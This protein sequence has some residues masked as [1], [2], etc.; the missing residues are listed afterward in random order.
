MN[1][2]KRILALALALMLALPA[3]ALATLVDDGTECPNPASPA[4]GL[5]V[6]RLVESQSANCQRPWTEV[7]RCEGCGKTYTQTYPDYGTHEFEYVGYTE[8]TCTEWG[9]YREECRVCG[10]VQEVLEGEPLGHLPY[11]DEVLYP[12]C[13]NDGYER[14]SCER[15][16]QVLDREILPARGHQWGN[17][18]ATS[19]TCTT[20]GGAVRVCSVCG[21]QEWDRPTDPLGH[22]WDGGR[23]TV[24]PTCTKNGERTFTCNR[25]GVTRTESIPA[26]GHK[27][28]RV[29]GWPPTCTENG[30]G[31]GEKCTVC[32]AVITA[33]NVIPATGHDWG[34]WNVTKAPTATEQGME[35]RICRN[36]SSHREYRYIPARG[37][38]TGEPTGQPT[39]D[40]AQVNP[41]LFLSAAWAEDAGVGKLYEGAVVEYTLT[42]TNT[43]DC[44]LRMIFS[45]PIFVSI[46]G[47]FGT[48]GLGETVELQ[49]G[50]TVTIAVH[51]SVEAV[52]VENRAYFTGWTFAGYYDDAPGEV[53]QVNSNAVYVN[54]PLTDPNGP[55]PAL[56]LTAAWAE[57]AGEGKCYEG[58]VVEFTLTCTNTG[59][60]P[61]EV[62]LE[63]PNFVSATGPS[64]A[65]S[66]SVTLQPGE[67]VTVVVHQPIGSLDVERQTYQ[68]LWMFMGFYI[69]AEG[70]EWSVDSNNADINIPLTYPQD[71]ETEEPKPA[72]TLIKLYDDPA[73]DVYE[74][75]D[76]GVGIF[77]DMVNTGNVP[78]RIVLFAYSGIGFSAEFE[79][80]ILYPGEEDFDKVYFTPPLSECLT[81]GT[82]T[83]DL[84]G[85][86]DLYLYCV[87]YDPETGEELC[88]TGEISGH[89]K[90]RK[91]GP[92]EWEI[93]DESQLQVTQDYGYIGGKV[94]G[95]L[96]L[97]AT[98]FA[99]ATVKNV[100][101]VDVDG[102]VIYIPAD[103]Y[104]HPN[105][106]VF[107]VDQTF[108]YLGYPNGKVTQEDVDRGYIYWPPVRVT[109]TDP[110]SGKVKTAYSESVTIPVTGD[111][112]LVVKKGIAHGPAN[113]EYF[114]AGEQID[115]VLT[116][117]NT[118]TA[119]IRNVTVTDK[120]V[121]VGSFAEIAPG[122]TKPC[123]VPPHIVSIYDEI[124]GQVI[125]MATAKG[126]TAWGAEVTRNSNVVVVPAGSLSTVPLIPPVLKEDGEIETPGTPGGPG[127]PG[128]GTPETPG[129]PG[130]PGGGEDPTG[131]IHGLKVGATIYKTDAHGPANGE[132]YV[133]GE[134][135]EFT[136]TVKNVGDVALENVVIYDSLAGIKPIDG[137]ASIA[138]GAE[139]TFTFIYFITQEDVNAVWVVNTAGLEYT[140][141]GGIKGTPMMSNQV[142]I[143]AG[144][145]TGTITPGGGTPG[146]WFKPL[147]PGGYTPVPGPG[148][149]PVITPGGSPIYTSGDGH[150]IIGPD[151]KLIKTDEHG[152]PIL[153]ENGNYIYLLGD[154]PVS[155]E[156][157]LTVMG[158]NEMRYTLHACANHVAAAQAAEAACAAGTAQGYKQAADIWR[159]EIDKMYQTLFEAA[160]DAAKATVMN[161]RLNLYAYVGTY[162]AMGTDPIRA[163]RTVAE[164]LRMHCAELCCMTHTVP[165]PLPNSLLG[166]YAMTQGSSE[167]AASSRTIAPLLG[168]DSEVV[169]RFDA[170]FARTLNEV[171][172]T[173]R[174]A[175]S[176]GRQEAFTQA[177]GQ[178]QMALDSVVNETYKA[179]DR[180]ARKQIAACRLMLDQY[181]A[182]RKAMLG[183][184]YQAAP[185][186]AEEA[187]MNLY[188]NAALEAAGGR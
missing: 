41:A 96:P 89:Y 178:W 153:D 187:L 1:K 174:G 172:D 116:V 31:Y 22:D 155:C 152:N 34:P 51:D 114:E 65:V 26:N 93:P 20:G 141:N 40:P 182:A 24:N 113:G 99:V 55:N 169:E 5:H 9:V 129:K 107:A 44:P 60:C 54:I 142:Y 39:G 176:A 71:G 90:V 161:D 76:T 75:D 168:S 145:I 80:G 50:E 72:L 48:V 73:K 33:Q 83:E 144:E 154:G 132:Y 121:T 74:P 179:A 123:S 36:D 147:P 177:Q 57:N 109:W 11:V 53:Q 105:S 52:D 82:E 15:C 19:A 188:K 137:A 163:Q 61:V 100:G 130:T 58:A 135:A 127:G 101:P 158:S 143:R 131:P 79:E 98:Y 27:P 8:P 118:S 115:W 126:T 134:Q 136:I 92:K 4:A 66:G 185:W 64:G 25:C 140:Y 157:R 104:T 170:S 42:L 119:P 84:M 18:E 49:P 6:W 125:N 37:G 7:F 133:L 23:V 122:E 59:D 35:E 78:L 184:L 43:G 91:P 38:A 45:N 162:E 175:G 21:A 120:G 102:Y 160:D 148:G 81:P 12:T 29:W 28:E 171:M 47:P 186:V 68:S 3:G 85:T 149:T 138:P 110:D 117:T 67:S 139:K 146:G 106:G 97:G 62:P 13:T 181:Y 166:T 94:N 77:C 183:M 17:W 150:G 180:E 70:E 156:M 14:Y 2:V 63:N 10:Q 111:S 46:T 124:I 95:K 87:G 32:G 69:N 151:G 103:D 86:A 16:G 128:G 173:V 108:G 159:E 164:M 167:N 56:S 30:M 88:R 165:A 112:G